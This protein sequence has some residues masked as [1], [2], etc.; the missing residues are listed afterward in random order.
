MKGILKKYSVYLALFALIAFN[1]IFTKNFFSI[2]TCWN[3]VIQSTTIMLVAL[4]MTV[5]IASGGIDI[6]IGPVMALSAIV[7]AKLLEHSLF[8]ALAAALGLA[9][10]CGALNGFIIAK[11]SIQPMIVTLG[12]MNMV[13]GFAELVNDGRTYSFMHPIISDLGFYKVGGVVP[14]QL[15]IIAAAIGFMFLLIRKMRFGAYVE[16]MGDN[17]KAAGLSGVNVSGMLILIYMLSGLMA[18]FAGLVEAARMSA[19][20]PINFGLQIEVDAIASTAIGG[21]NMAGGK[22]NLAGTVAGVFIMQIIT[23]M[24]NMNNIPYSYSLVIKTL[25]VIIAVCAQNGRISA[26]W[27]KKRVGIN[28]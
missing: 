8:Q 1:S 22:A 16:A 23:V 9:L 15:F 26:L 10:A 6:S 18:G 12:M 13:R 27:N 25:V 4:G 7:F 11:F 17:L 21:T 5:A 14:I 28:A 19:A 24:V 20:D 2:N 3:I